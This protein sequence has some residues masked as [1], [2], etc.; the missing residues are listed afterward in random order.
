MLFEVFHKLIDA[1]H[2]ACDG[3]FLWTMRLALVT[4]DAMAGLPLIGQ[5]LVVAQEEGAAVASV[6]LGIGIAG[7][8]VAFGDAV[9]VMRE[10]GGDVQAIGT[11]HAVIAGS[12]RHGLQLHK[13]LGDFHQELK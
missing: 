7:G 5:L 6:F 13:L 4:A 9:V 11:R 8:H 10:D 12:A 2:L 3:D 1:L